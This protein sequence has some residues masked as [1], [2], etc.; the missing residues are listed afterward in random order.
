[1]I[2][3]FYILNA[4][5]GIAKN[6][7]IILS[8]CKFV[9]EDIDGV[10]RVH[11][12]RC[13]SVMDELLRPF[14]TPFAQELI[15]RVVLLYYQKR[16]YRFAQDPKVQY[17]LP[18]SRVH[19]QFSWTMEDFAPSNYNSGEEVFAEI[20]D[21]ITSDKRGYYDEND[22]RLYYE[23]DESR[24][25]FRRKLAAIN[26]ETFAVEEDDADCQDV[27]Y[28]RAMAQHAKHM[29]GGDDDGLSAEERQCLGGMSLRRLKYL[30][31][32][33]E[34][35][36]KVQRTAEAAEYLVCLDYC[37]GVDEKEV[38]R[39]I[40]GYSAFIRSLLALI[41]G[42]FGELASMVMILICGV[43]YILWSGARVGSET[44]GVEEIILASLAIVFI[45]EIDDAIYDHALPELYK[46]AH[47]RDRFHV[48]YWVSSEETAEMEHTDQKPIFAKL[49]SWW[50]FGLFEFCPGG[51]SLDSFAYFCSFGL[52]RCN[53]RSDKMGSDIYRR[54][55][56]TRS[57]L[58]IGQGSRSSS[59]RLTSSPS[60]RFQK[61]LGRTSISK[62]Q[63]PQNVVVL[64]GNKCALPLARASAEG[65]S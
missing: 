14:R 58:E 60:S 25:F 15:N 17:F 42:V 8:S 55:S 52:I 9:S 51:L 59:V 50:P 62:Q 43:Q 3:L 13:C 2:F 36:A 24:D 12:W 44:N 19:T 31:E 35:A 61:R 6:T 65:R 48:E 27:V 56:V 26:P 10:T 32:R 33:E 30:L 23:I 22:T 64:K 20:G 16:K 54:V 40:T 34:T 29:G 45:N 41:F 57:S 63:L 46:T 49:F 11:Y 38:K 1:M 18:L 5:P 28:Q 7:I 39:V 47:E 4:V 37:D 53:Q 21:W